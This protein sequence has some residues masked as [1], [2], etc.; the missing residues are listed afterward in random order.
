MECTRSQ[1]L[2]RSVLSFNWTGCWKSTIPSRLRPSISSHLY[3]PFAPLS[4]RLLFPRSAVNCRPTADAPLQ[5]L[6][7]STDP[8]FQSRLERFQVK[9]LTYFPLFI[10]FATALPAEPQVA[11]PPRLTLPHGQAFSAAILSRENLRLAEALDGQYDRTEQLT[12]VRV[13][14]GDSAPVELYRVRSGRLQ[15]KQALLDAQTSY[16]QAARDVLNLLNVRPEDLTA[17][18]IASNDATLTL[19]SASAA[20]AAEP[21]DLLPALLQSSPVDL[22]GTLTDRDVPF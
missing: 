4:A 14:T 11:R 17:A 10:L 19:V 13:D 1:E 9:R 20:A 5:S 12:K 22:T 15:Y 16:N 3:F 8:N 2:P 6:S 18:G 21:Q 7:K